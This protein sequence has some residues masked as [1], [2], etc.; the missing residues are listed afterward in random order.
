M[1]PSLAFPA[2]WLPG[3]G[4]RRPDPGAAAGPRSGTGGAAGL[5]HDCRNQPEISA[6]SGQTA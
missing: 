3:T 1:R 4:P 6:L 2:V 5:H